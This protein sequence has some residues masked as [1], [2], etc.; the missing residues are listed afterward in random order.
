MLWLLV[1]DLLVLGVASGAVVAG[2]GRADGFPD[3]RPR[4]HGYFWPNPQWAGFA[5]KG[6]GLAEV[7][8]RW[9]VPSV[10][11]YREDSNVSFW[12]G[13]DGIGSDTVEQAGV[14]V[15]CRR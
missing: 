9:Q 11:C 6:D 12:V 8:S 1:L 13:L 3:I 10:V 2:L 7:S 4:V 5:A 14:E 15:L